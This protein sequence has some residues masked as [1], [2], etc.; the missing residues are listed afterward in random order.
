MAIDLCS[1]PSSAI[2]P[3][4]SFSHDFCLS[5]FD[6]QQ[7]QQQH[8]Y[9]SASPGSS[10]DFDFCVRKSSFDH[11][12]SSSADELF[13]DGKILPTAIKTAAVVRPKPS[14]PPPSPHP[15]PRIEE[16]SA[17][18][19][20]DDNHRREEDE[21]SKQQSSSKSFWRFK[22]SSSVN[23]STGYGRSLCPL[24][25][26]SRSNSTG[27]STASVKRA[28][29]SAVAAGKQHKQQPAAAAASSDH[30]KPPLRKVG[31]GGYGGSGASAGVRVSPVLNMPSGNLF[32]L[33]SIFSG[34]SK[35][36]SKSKK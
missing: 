18:K 34:H 28:P 1:E 21:E 2:S 13:S 10:I 9:R 30:R 16:S 33:G 8:P 3:R 6:Q 23:C 7:Q 35:D 22:R 17:G 36:K 5:E 19:E 25:L 29:F 24:P 31:H 12:P 27:S 32:G 20:I 4:I 11:D 14:L 15:K 26:L